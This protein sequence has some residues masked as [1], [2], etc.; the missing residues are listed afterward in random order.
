L[1]AV[2]ASGDDEA[3]DGDG[4]DVRK[5]PDDASSAWASRQRTTSGSGSAS[6][7]EDDP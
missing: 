4:A 6:G 2:V 1:A 7:D 5:T 3:D